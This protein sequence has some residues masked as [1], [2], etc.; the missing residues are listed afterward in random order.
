MDYITPSEYGGTHPS[1]TNVVTE[2]PIVVEDEV[3]YIEDEGIKGN[4]RKLLRPEQKPIILMKYLINKFTTGADIV[5]DTCA[6]TFSTLKVCMSMDN[7]R[8]FI[9][10]DIDESCAALVKDSRFV[11]I[12]FYQH[13]CHASQTSSL[14]DRISLKTEYFF[15]RV[16]K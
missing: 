14:N 11:C 1:W 7:H 2:V 4:R 6:G 5:V 12:S 13:R 16:K 8:Q 10:T 9:G 15:V 3:V